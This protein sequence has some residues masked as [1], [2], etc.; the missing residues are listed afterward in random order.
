M[1][2]QATHIDG[3]AVASVEKRKAI[4]AIE[5]IIVARTSGNILGFTVRPYGFF[6]K[7]LY[8]SEN[9]ILDI[10]KNGIVIR[11]EESLADISEIIR[12]KK[13]L[14]DGFELIGLKAITKNKTK[15]GKIEDYVIQTNN[16]EITKYYLS[17]FFSNRIIG[18]EKV[19]KITKKEI[20]F[21]DDIQLDVSEKEVNKALATD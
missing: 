11:S 8:L 16:L 5:K 13:I 1:F 15:L 17:G 18:S 3:L 12:A 14:D 4:G 21:K 19:H 7:D 2:L 6:K 9:D 10:D 20:V